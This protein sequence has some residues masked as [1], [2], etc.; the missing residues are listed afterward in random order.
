MHCGSIEFPCVYFLF[1]R[2]ASYCGVEPHW[3]VAF[4]NSATPLVGVLKRV[5]WIACET[6]TDL[7]GSISATR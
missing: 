6:D 4:D 1:Q 7:R 5:V 3:R 2:K